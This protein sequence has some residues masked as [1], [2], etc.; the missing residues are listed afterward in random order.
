MVRIILFIVFMCAFFCSWQ[1]AEATGE[2]GY[3]VATI[4]SGFA[5]FFQVLAI[6][7]WF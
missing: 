6:G 4:L 2:K 3:Y 7:G 5:A 1:T